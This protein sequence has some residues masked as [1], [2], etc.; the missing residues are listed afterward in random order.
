[1]SASDSRVADALISA[2]PAALNRIVDLCLS[3][4]ADFLVIAGDIYESAAPNVRSRL[5]FSGAMDRLASEGI[6][7]YCVSGN[8]DPDD[9]PSAGDPLPTGVTRFSNDTVERIEHRD[10]DGELLCAVYGRS[11]PRSKVTDDYAADFRRHPA[12]PLAV[13]VLHTNVGGRPGYED[14][15]PSTSEDLA[16]AG[17]DY[18]ALGHIHACGQASSNV[19]AWYAGSPQGLQPNATG[20]HGCLLVTCAAG[21]VP[22]V[23]FKPTASVVWECSTADLETACSIEDVQR[24]V[25]ATCELARHEAGAPVSM[26]IELTGRCEVAEQLSQPGALIDLLEAV[27]ESSMEREPWVWVDRLDDRSHRSLD[28]DAYRDEGGFAGDLVRRADRL[29]DETEAAA[30][31]KELLDMARASLPERPEVS[32]PPSTLVERARDRCLDLLA[33]GE[34]R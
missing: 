4:R 15:A 9:G 6:P 2:V 1:V 19:P 22:T 10:A 26:R 28:L 29:M 27:R 23:E 33:G 3:E 14:Y 17:M 8:H 31:L 24:A 34:D 20:A 18:W 21:I 16:A 30:A 13:G 12:D 25:D 11:Y 7:V 5:A 32:A